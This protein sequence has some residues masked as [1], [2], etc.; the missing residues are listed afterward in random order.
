M[1]NAPMNE[2]R[3]VLRP[4][5]GKD[6]LWISSTLE[7]DSAPRVVPGEEVEQVLDAH[8]AV[9]GSGSV[10]EVGARRAGVV[11]A[12]VVE[13]VFDAHAAIGCAGSRSIIHI[14]DAVVQAV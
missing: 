10:V 5:S 3:A 2:P 14:G 1:V 6:E 13:E 7:I 8:A 12:E 11:E 9:G 4:P